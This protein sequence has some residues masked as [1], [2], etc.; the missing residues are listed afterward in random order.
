MLKHKIKHKYDSALIS[1]GTSKYLS[2]TPK[3]TRLAVALTPATVAQKAPVQ[4]E[5]DSGATVIHFHLDT[6]GATV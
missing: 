6:V 3:W 2:A 1:S 5:S 4:A